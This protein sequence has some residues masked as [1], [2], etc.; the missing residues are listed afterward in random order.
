MLSAITSTTFKYF[1]S[2]IMTF[3]CTKRP[4]T[5]MTEP[6]LQYS[7]KLTANACQTLHLIKSVSYSKVS[8]FLKFLWTANVISVTVL[9]SGK[10]LISGSF[11]NLPTKIVWFKIL[12]LLSPVNKLYL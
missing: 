6:F 12:S 3:L 4:L 1:S 8:A 5:P 11:V 9:P 7:P 10:F 2:S